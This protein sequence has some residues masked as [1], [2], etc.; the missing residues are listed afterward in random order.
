[1]SSGRNPRKPFVNIIQ[2]FFVVKFGLSLNPF[3]FFIIAIFISSGRKSVSVFIQLNTECAFSCQK[4]NIHKIFF[5]QIINDLL[6]NLLKI[7]RN[8]RNV[9]RQQRPFAEFLKNAVFPLKSDFAARLIFRTQA[10]DKIR[11]V[12]ARMK[13]N[14]ANFIL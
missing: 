7:I 1:M 10:L 14:K 6:P 9:H 12:V 3:A 8:R 13:L 4:R 2:L 11:V 5:I